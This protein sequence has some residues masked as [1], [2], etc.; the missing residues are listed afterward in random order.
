MR[1]L[2]PFLAVAVLAA[3]S[4]VSGPEPSLAPRAAEAIDPRVPIPD[5]LPAGTAD[6]AL[7][8]QLD[9]LVGQVRAGVAPFQERLAVADRLAAA[10][11]P[12]SSESWVAAQSALSLLVE[13]NGVT[14]RAAADIDA[15]AASRLQQQHWIRPAD[16]GAITAAAGEVAAIGGPQAAA[17][18]RIRDRLAR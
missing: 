12:I 3:C 16:Q 6:A 15:L 8:R 14:T 11:G 5:T 17:I 10:A 13:Q 2:S 7:A 1:R 9:Q 4:P 18:A